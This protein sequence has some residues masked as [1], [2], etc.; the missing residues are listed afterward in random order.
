MKLQFISTSQQIPERP[1]NVC[2]LIGSK[3]AR[4]QIFEVSCP[5][6]SLP[7]GGSPGTCVQHLCDSGFKLNLSNYLCEPTSS[8]SQ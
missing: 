5:V 1:G 8:S 6:G 2:G 3:L 7:L 4:T